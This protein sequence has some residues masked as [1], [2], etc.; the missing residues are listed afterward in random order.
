MRVTKIAKLYLPVNSN[1]E[2]TFLWRLQAKAKTQFSGSSNKFC[3]KLC[4]YVSNIQ[5]VK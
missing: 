3:V 2:V 1:Y 5:F 4:V